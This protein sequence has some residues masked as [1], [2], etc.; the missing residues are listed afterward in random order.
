MT[1]LLEYLAKNED[2]SSSVSQWAPQ[3][4]VDAFSARNY[5]SC[6]LCTLASFGKNAPRE[7]V[8]YC[9]VVLCVAMGVF[10]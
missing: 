7:Y 9:V 1:S 8:V 4:I 5:T 2:A 10:G 6:N 3:K